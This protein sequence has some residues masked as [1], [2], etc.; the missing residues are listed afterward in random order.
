MKH[1][2]KNFFATLVLVFALVGCQTMPA[3]DT[4]GKRF[5]VA[6][7]ALQETLKTATLYAN[8]GR[9][10]EEQLNM[11]DQVFDKTLL[12][13]EVALRAW[14][15]NDMETF[16]LQMQALTVSLQAA[17]SILLEVSP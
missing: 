15:D 2:M 13:R 4:P 16:D 12:V 3:I 14:I 1:A 8:E 11:L 10:N 6:E 17:R 9:L 5:A 7:I